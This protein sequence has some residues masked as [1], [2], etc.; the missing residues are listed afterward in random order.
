MPTKSVKIQSSIHRIIIVFVILIC[1]VSAYFF[2]KWGFA[3]TIS[4]RTEYREIADFTTYLAPSDPQTHYASAVLHEKSFLPEDFQKSLS[5]YEK[6]AALSPNDYLL[7]L[8]LGKARE[9]S[10]DAEGAEKA[11]RKSAELAP[12]YTQVQ[13]TL[14]N[15]LLRRGKTVEAFT[16]I[17]KAVVSDEKYIDP[18][19]STAWQVSDGDISQVKKLVGDSV[20]IKSAL[21]LFLANRKRFDEAFEIWNLLPDE[22]KKTIFKPNSEDFYKQLVAEKKFRTAMTVFTQISTDEVQK[23]ELGKI[24]NGGFENE[25][26]TQD[27]GIFEWRITDGAQP[28]IALNDQTKHGGNRSLWLIFNSSDGK[29]F[30][31][32]SQ[33]VAVET[34]RIYEFE[35]FYKSELKAS[36]TIRWE[37]TDAADGKVLA[38][39]ETV[40]ANSDWTTLKTKFSISAPTEAVTIRLA[41]ANCASSICPISGKIWFDDFSLK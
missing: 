1:F 8:A 28:Q 12:N 27:A 23:T 22:A 11:L 17:R 39:T 26:K 20:R 19:V 4:T 40:S 31:T 35:T 9:R 18:A 10:G 32:I 30:R 36:A 16:E 14:G 21:T 24:V 38:S 37:I 15:I 34:G 7:W 5:E 25:I 13:W 3:N 29:G 33:T 2:T 6:A 41:R